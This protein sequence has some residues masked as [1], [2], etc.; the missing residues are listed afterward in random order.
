MISSDNPSK[1]WP[2]DARDGGKGLY[3][4][5]CADCNGQFMGYKRRVICKECHKEAAK[6]TKPRPQFYAMCFPALQDIAKAKGYNLI[7][8]GSLNRDM[9]LVAV[10]WID[11]PRPEL[12]LIQAFDM[13]LRG[14]EYE[15]KGAHR[16]YMHSTLPGG[17]HSYV[18]HL[19]RG[20]IWNGYN[21]EQYYLDISVTPLQKR[22]SG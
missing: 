5:R 14:T 7:M 12:E 11:E 18:I 21:D 19:N 10:P 20:G 9:D 8:H 13:F 3:L 2:E 16:G 17:R 4:C 15:E 22:I 6:P 1:D